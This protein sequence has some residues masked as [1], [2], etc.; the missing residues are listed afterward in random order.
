M[1]LRNENSVTK[2]KNNELQNINHIQCNK[3]SIRIYGWSLKKTRNTR[4]KFL[5]SLSEY[6]VLRMNEFRLILHTMV[7]DRLT[8]H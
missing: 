8:N 7:L 2:Y 4:Q 6:Q 1:T 3:Q 5:N